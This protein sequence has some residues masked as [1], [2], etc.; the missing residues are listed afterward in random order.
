LFGDTGPGISIDMDL[1]RN[2]FKQEQIDPR[3]LHVGVNACPP[4][5]DRRLDLCQHRPVQPLGRAARRW[6]IRVG[7]RTDA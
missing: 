1:L 2:V 7:H 5:G 3:W 4:H 6:Q